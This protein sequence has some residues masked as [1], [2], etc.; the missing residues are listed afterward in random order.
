MDKFVGILGGMGTEATS[1]F[2]A[3]LMSFVNATSD[4][5]HLKVL[6]YNN[7]KIP[8]RT[9]YILNHTNSPLGELITSAKILE[10]A[11]VDF[12]VIPCNAAHHFYDEIKKNL[13]IPLIDITREV[14]AEI[15]INKQSK[16][17]IGLCAT[18]GAIKAAIY[19]KSFEAE[20]LK[21]YTPNELEQNVI[22]E[23]IYD[24][25][26]KK[27]IDYD[28]LSSAINNF[29]LCHQINTL[30]LGC[31]EL[32]LIKNKLKLSGIVVMDSNTILAYRT[33]QYAKNM[34]E[35]TR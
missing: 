13:S 14:L 18:T 19:E 25:K 15:Q 4:Q 34:I 26:N 32:S 8:D 28:R 5:E 23:V 10:H 20:G 21:L 30:I 9:N 27:H 2:Y 3:Q 31:T 17:T 1:Y 11:G 16:T 35:V 24:I 22:N 33:Y 6:L 29:C 7:S 12:I